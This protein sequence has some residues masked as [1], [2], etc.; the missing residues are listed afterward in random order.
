MRLMS[1]F[2][3]KFFEGCGPPDF[4]YKKAPRLGA[5]FT[6]LLSGFNSL[7]FEFLE[8]VFNEVD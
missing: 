3:K 7:G 6:W 4:G 5:P 2:S 8:M 1:P